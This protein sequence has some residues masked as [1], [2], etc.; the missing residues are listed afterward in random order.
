MN[1]LML[2]SQLL[3]VPLYVAGKSPEQVCQELG[4]SEA[5]KLGSKPRSMP[6]MSRHGGL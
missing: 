6:L 1:G 3:K 2:N 4:L 5:M